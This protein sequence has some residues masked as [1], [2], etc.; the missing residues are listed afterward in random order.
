MAEARYYDPETGGST[1]EAR[2]LCMD[3]VVHDSFAARELAR[4]EK[5]GDDMQRER[6][7]AL[8]ELEGERDRMRAAWDF[9][10]DRNATL[11]SDMPMSHACD[12]E[13]VW[14]CEF[15]SGDGETVSFGSDTP[16]AAVEAAV[17][18]WSARNPEVS[19]E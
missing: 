6:D 12:S 18:D 2:D 19:D 7:E 9:L 13:T 15:A 16:L 14:W 5:R 10:R 4:L 8:A 11:D 17:A 1:T 3:N